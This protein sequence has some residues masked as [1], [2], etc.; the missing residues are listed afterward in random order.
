[1]TKKTEVKGEKTVLDVLEEKKLVH[2]LPAGPELVAKHRNQYTGVIECFKTKDDE[3]WS[4]DEIALKI[5]DGLVVKAKN[6]QG[7]ID[8]VDVT[9]EGDLV[10]GEFNLGHLPDY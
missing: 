4:I 2:K 5:D 6:R 8:V 7:K 9:E 10:I 3:E 1:M